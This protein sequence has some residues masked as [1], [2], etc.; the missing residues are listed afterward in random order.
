MATEED[1]NEYF[2]SIVSLHSTFTETNPITY[3]VLLIEYG[4]KLTQEQKDYVIKQRD[5]YSQKHKETYAEIMKYIDN[6]ISR[7]PLTDK[8][9]ESENKIIQL[10]KI[11]D[12]N[13]VYRLPIG[14][15]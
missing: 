4:D 11:E 10:N 2:E 15:T 8:I 6:D 1:I 9:N 12:E 14:K 7:L 13:V 5:F 3:Q